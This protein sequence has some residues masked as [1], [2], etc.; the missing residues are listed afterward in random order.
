MKY[1]EFKK[2]NP[3]MKLVATLNLLSKFAKDFE[4]EHGPYKV[5]EENTMFN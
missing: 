4:N 1:S 5:P 2:N 3:D